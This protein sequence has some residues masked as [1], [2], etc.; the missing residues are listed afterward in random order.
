[1]AEKIEVGIT[2]KGADAA[3]KEVNKVDSATKGLGGNIDMAT[4]ALD[5][6]TGGAVSAFKGIISGV[7]KAVIGMKTLKTAIIST[8]I[9]ALV[10]A[11]VSLVAYFTSSRKG[12]NQLK[13]AMAA[14]GA[15]VERVTGYFAAAGGYLKNL[16]TVG[17]K[18]A[19][20]AFNEEIKKLP[21]S[22]Q[23]VIDKAIELEKRSQALRNT[24]RDMTVAFAEGRAQIK[25]YNMVA[26][27]VTRSLKDRLEAAQKAIDIERE[28]MAERQR[29][30]QEEYDIALERAAQSDTS[31]EDL[32]NLAALE[33]TLI[34]I[35]T[36]SA[37]M[38]TT[39]NNKLNIIRQQSAAAAQAEADAVIEAE[40][41]KQDALKATAEI[42]AKIRAEKEGH[43]FNA[44]QSLRDYLKTEEEL[45]IEAFDKKAAALLM[46]NLTAGEDANKLYEKLDKER[47]AIT[48]KYNA[49]EVATAEAT[50]QAVRA[51]RLGIVAAGFQA[52]QS[53]AKTEEGQKKLAISQILVN[54]G[55]AMAEA[56]R[57]AMQSATG[58]GPLAAF[59]A[60]GFTATMIGMVLSSFASIKGVMNQAGAS[61]GSIGTSSAGGS[62]AG[63]QL[64]LTPNIEGVTQIQEPVA[65]VKAF[66]VQSELADESALV[67][68]LKA[69]AS[70]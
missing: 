28:L 65:P 26:E 12:A 6:M 50:A 58:T 67:A 23:D 17:H 54:Q 2:I 22:M 8:G 5:K 29:N 44:E 16:F 43:Q 18:A 37:E 66:V 35:R 63:M 52:L 33:V 19:A 21:G 47:Q 32:D 42:E 45:E 13:V 30:A 60:P 64:G 36:E 56:Y 62:S 3:T 51:A 27:D 38:Q 53:M 9:G 15:V 1:M 20:V 14:M 46:A 39:L 68:Q 69:M 49:E 10:V 70:L 61:S 24:Q 59:T 41:E 48:D 55:I 25:E 7:K 4:G 57:G 11:V 31:E 40:K 34:N